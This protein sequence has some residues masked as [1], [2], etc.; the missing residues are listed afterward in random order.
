MIEENQIHA[1]DYL[2]L[3]AGVRLHWSEVRQQHWLLFPEGA[4]ALN[5]TA[6]AILAQ[7]NGYHSFEAI[8]TALEKQFSDVKE[9]DLQDLL[10]YMMKRGLLINQA[11]L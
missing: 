10:S 1:L 7:C 4:L 5:S 3:S 2:G 9:S 11:Q 6:V 8:A